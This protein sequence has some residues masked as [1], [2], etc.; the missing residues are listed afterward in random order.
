[1]PINAVKA[2]PHDVI[3]HFIGIGG[4]GMSGLARILAEADLRVQGSDLRASS[5]TEQLH[6]LGAQVFIGHDAAHLG[7][8][9]IV[10]Y[11]TDV[12]E[13]NVE[14]QEAVRRGLT[15]WHRSDLLARLLNANRGIAVTGTHGKTTT[16]AMIGSLL[17]DAGLDP[18]ISVGG[19]IERW[20]GTGRLGRSDWVVAEACE[21]DGTFLRYRPQ[22][23]VLTNVEAEHLEHYA[24]SFER[25]QAAMAQFVA[26]VPQDGLLLA[27]ADDAGAMQAAAQASA[28][29]VRYGLGDAADVAGRNLRLGP[30]GWAFD[31]VAYGKRAGAVQLQVPGR[32]NVRNALAAIAL[33]LELDVPFAVI[34]ESLGA[35]RGSKRRFQVLHAGGVTVVD[36]YAHHPTEIAATLA[37][38][39]ER[40]Q[41]GRV[42]AVFQPH[43]YAR[44]QRLFEQF[45]GCFDDSDVLIL[46]EIYA[47]AGEAQQATISGRDLA[48]R[49]RARGTCD[50]HFVPGKEDAHK[51]L[52]ALAR[53]GDLVITMGAGDISDVGHRFA[54][55]CRMRPASR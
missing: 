5:R 27:C 9:G 13:H 31:V 45:T 36:D 14:R 55:R 46:T 30:D 15:L 49:V 12:P 22:I 26:Q 47:P 24:D 54:E 18:T 43:R 48:D 2:I 32:H 44:T 19:E 23:A 52:L 42:L 33:G 4:Y 29:V 28:R 8:A 38:A 25:L 3:Y 37:A 1:M 50:V 21:S 51:L 10:L 7:E 20:H 6:A 41:G 35:F 53:P 11:S 39:R 34:A 40:A 17:L 16:T